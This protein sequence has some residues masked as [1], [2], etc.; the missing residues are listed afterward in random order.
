M[1]RPASEAIER[2]AQAVCAEPAHVT[3]GRPMHWRTVGPIG[4]ALGLNPDACDAAVS[5]ALGR[6]WLLGEGNPPHSISLTD[7]GRVMAAKLK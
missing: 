3:G 7:G 1:T 2:R 6:D 4:A 5:H